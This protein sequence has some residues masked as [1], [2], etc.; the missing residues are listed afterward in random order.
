MKFIKCLIRPI[1]VFILLF[2]AYILAPRDT[3]TTHEALQTIIMGTVGAIALTYG[4]TLRLF[5][6]K[7]TPGRLK[8]ALTSGAISCS[9]A[10]SATF[11]AS[12]IFNLAAHTGPGSELS[13]LIAVALVAVIMTGLI[14]GIEEYL[15]GSP[16]QHQTAEREALHR[17]NNPQNAQRNPPTDTSFN[18]QDIPSVL[19]WLNHLNGEDFVRRVFGHTYQPLF[20]GK[21]SWYSLSPSDQANFHALIAQAT[22]DGE[23]PPAD[24]YRMLTGKAHTLDLRDLPETSEPPTNAPSPNPTDHGITYGADRNTLACPSCGGKYMHQTAIEIHTRLHELPKLFRPRFSRLKFKP[25][26]VTRVNLRTGKVSRK[27]AHENISQD[28]PS[29]IIEFTCGMCSAFTNIKS[30]L[31]LG[32][33][34]DDVTTIVEWIP[35]PNQTDGE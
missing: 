2:L 25:P 17:R 32:I 23:T 27:N 14:F 16:H 26:T 29:A 9:I 18:N 22:A 34:Q 13:A 30:V 4:F 15:A 31:T 12:S 6:E 28:R 7:H 11:L 5:N 33:W 3:E 10:I 8:K 19:D 35:T 1:T 21:L 24:L 20:S